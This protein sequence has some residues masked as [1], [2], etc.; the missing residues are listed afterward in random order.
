MAKKSKIAKTKKLNRRKEILLALGEKRVNRVS[1]R[2]QNRCKICGRPRGFMRF[3]GVCRLCFRELASRGELAG[4][5]KAS[6]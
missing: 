1:T 5:T 6:K 4:V 3:F 2:N